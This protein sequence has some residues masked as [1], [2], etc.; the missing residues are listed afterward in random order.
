MATLRVWGGAL[1]AALLA[2]LGWHIYVAYLA[3]MP[4]SVWRVVGAT[5]VAWAAWHAYRSFIR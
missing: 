3:V 4:P 1:A 5:W 2:L